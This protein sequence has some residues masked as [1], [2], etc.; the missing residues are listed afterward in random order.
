MAANVDIKR[1]LEAPG[2]VLDVRSPG[3]FTSGH[4]PGAINLPLFED[5]ERAQVG[6]LYKQAGKR[7][8]LLEGLSLVGPKLRDL[9]LNAQRHAKESTAKV[10]CWRGGM[11]SEA[12]SWLL[13]LTGLPTITLSGGYKSFRSF[14]QSTFNERYPLLVIGGLTGCGKTELL[15]HLRTFGQQTI[16]IEGLARHRGSSFGSRGLQPT[17]EQFE[18]DLALQLSLCDKSRPIWIEDESRMVGK[19][20]VPGP[21]F[22]QLRAAPLFL[23]QKSREER[24]QRLVEEYG[25]SAAAD[26]IAAVRKIEKRLGGEKTRLVC[27]HI[28][29]GAYLEAVADMLVYYDKAYDFALARRSGPVVSIDAHCLTLTA[30]KLAQD[31]FCSGLNLGEKQALT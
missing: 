1:F 10:H 18:N 30:D 3:E 21:L 17:Q 7:Q 2:V 19:C 31:P 22:S 6:T 29:G 15:S 23:L 26:L 20:Q 11:R 24:I 25:V 5:E 27:K 9:A 4:I 28:A 12:V 13:R 16:D 8:A 14:A